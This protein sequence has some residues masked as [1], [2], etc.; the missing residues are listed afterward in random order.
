ME[1]EGKTVFS[2][3]HYEMIADFL[4]SLDPGPLSRRELLDLL[5]VFFEADN[6]KFNKALF[7][8]RVFG[9]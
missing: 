4:S 3:K 1:R 8:K 2:K 5:E 6:P 7:E 9:F